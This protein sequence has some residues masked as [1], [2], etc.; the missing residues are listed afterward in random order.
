MPRRP[1]SLRDWDERWYKSEKGKEPNLK[2]I[3]DSVNRLNCTNVIIVGDFNIREIGWINL[4][5][6][7]LIESTFLDIVQNN[8]LFQLVSKPTKGENI[9]DLVLVDNID[10]VSSV[11]VVNS[12][13]TSDHCSIDILLSAKYERIENDSRKIYLYSK[14]D[15][16]SLN[17]AVNSIDWNEKFNGTTLLQKW[18]CLKD[19]VLV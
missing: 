10:L 9:L 3:C 19:T 1:P 8:L 15:Y 14:G 4:E 11:D 17:D 18:E 12:F 13:S 6:K 7:G 2:T 16:V 5:A